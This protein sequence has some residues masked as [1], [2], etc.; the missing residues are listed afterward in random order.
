MSLNLKRFFTGL[1]I[2]PKITPTIDTL[3]EFEVLSTTNKAYFNDGSISSALVTEDGTN[4]L[5][6]KTLNNPIINNATLSID[7]PSASSLHIQSASSLTADRNLI[8]NVNDANRTIALNGNIT[9]AGDFTTSG[10]N[11]L[12]LTTTASTNITLP[13]SGT[14]STLNGVET[15]TNKTLTNPIINGALTLSLQD[16][17]TP[18]FNL[19]LQ[20]RSTA[21]V[22]NSDH[23]LIFDV[24]SADRVI[25]LSGDLVIGGQFRTLGPFNI[26]LT[27]TAGTAVT[28]PTS[29]TLATLAGAEVFTNKDIDGG[30]ASNTD[31]I[32]LP[33]NSTANLTALTRKQ[34]TIVYD[35]TLNIAKL[36]DGSAL[37]DIIKTATSPGATGEPIVDTTP[38]LNGALQ[39]KK[40]IAGTNIVLTPTAD[41]LT[42]TSTGGGG[43]GGSAAGI[44][45]L[46]QKVNEEHFGIAT[47][48]YT[49]SLGLS[50]AN[51]VNATLYT[52]RLASPYT[53]SDPTMFI[54]WNPQ[55]PNPADPDMDSAT[56]WSNVSNATNITTSA[57]A[58]IGTA[59][60][61][62]DKTAGSTLSEI[63]Y[64]RGSNN[65]NIFNY[66]NVWMWVNLP[67]ATL[68]DTGAGGLV[69]RV[70]DSA[71]TKSLS[72]SALTQFD[73]SPFV[74]GWNFLYFDFSTGATATGGATLHDIFRYVYFGFLT[75]SAADTPAGTLIDGIMFGYNLADQIAPIAAEFTVYDS[76]N[77]DTILIDSSNT[78][79]TGELTLTASVANSYPGGISSFIQRD[80]LV[81]GGNQAA[82]N[83]SATGDEEL[84]QEVRAS[85]LF[86]S[87]FAGDFAAFADINT[88]QYY[89]VNSVGGSS[90]DLIDFVNTSADIV[91]GNVLHVF[92]QTFIDGKPFYIY[93]ADLAV[94]SSS[95]S[96]NILTVNCT[97]GATVAGDIVVKQHV[98]SY[99]SVENYGVNENFTSLSP[100]ASPDGILLFDTGIGI[101]N[102]QFVGGHWPLGGPNS[103]Y[104]AANLQGFSPS[105]TIVGSVP[106]TNPFLNGAYAAGPFSSANYYRLT[107]AES[108][109]YFA[110]SGSDPLVAGSIWIYLNSFPSNKVLLACNGT[111][112]AGWLLNTNST[113]NVEARFNNAVS[114]TSSVTMLA[115]TWNHIAFNFRGSGNLAELWVNGT[116]NSGTQGATTISN[117]ELR[118]GNDQFNTIPFDNGFI[119]DLVLESNGPGFNQAQID[120]LYNAGNSRLLGFNPMLRYQYTDLSQSGQRLSMKVQLDR[121]TNAVS[122]FISAFG[123][124]AKS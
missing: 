91:S 72:K 97:P 57:T 100:D 48:P 67:D 84:T 30:T 121:T 16:I 63:K 83:S 54:V 23:N 79:S 70:V 56:G 119:A 53:A 45:L 1:Q 92:S 13:T 69:L 94:T 52:G 35:S 11:P 73:G 50:F 96:A 36:D 115:N 102:Q 88:P 108:T 40:L 41:S 2:V 18:A 101:P 27:A 64:D 78:D 3:G 114:I 6:N 39:F 51:T 116:Y 38:V 43:G 26:D 104:A 24:K 90:I 55:Y 68:I 117:Q 42:I 98:T 44:E 80:T 49:N 4:T 124:L 61:S 76:T 123:A 32:T 33:K 107:G 34:A 71:V 110:A 87:V 93:K 120:A 59:S 60:I 109:P 31:R 37:F 14:L 47:A 22:L 7:D 112:S 105:L 46:E 99:L 74:T 118:V 10:A 20:S 111:D 25:D 77:K 66:T 9:T 21:P 81:L 17:V 8:F 5:N 103:T 89:T 28:L 65:L 86:R 106:F 58:K 12:T 122:P 113:P 15:L 75:N 85:T 95:W 19:V 29:G 62:Y 82:F